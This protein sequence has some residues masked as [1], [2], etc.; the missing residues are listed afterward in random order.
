MADDENILNQVNRP[1]FSM[2]STT[3]PYVVNGQPVWGLMRPR[4][5]PDV[6]DQVF[7]MTSAGQRRL[8][9]VSMV[10]YQTPE[11]WDI[12]AQVNNIHDPLV[13]VAEGSTLRIPLKSRLAALGIVNSK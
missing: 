6:T 3:A 5:S 4:V 7:T 12:I 10:F 1:A 9:L 13:G 11:L 2:F 8:D